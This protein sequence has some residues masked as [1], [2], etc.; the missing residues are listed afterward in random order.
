MII[1]K[2]EGM[3]K[4]QQLKH[5]QVKIDLPDK[6][7]P[8]SDNRYTAIK[9]GITEGGETRGRAKVF[10][11]NNIYDKCPAEVTKLKNIRL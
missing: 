3:G 7:D 10:F 2:A 1:P 9:K 11:K 5:W 8:H 4:T 6:S